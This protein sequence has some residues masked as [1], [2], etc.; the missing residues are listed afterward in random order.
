MRIEKRKGRSIFEGLPIIL[1]LIP[2]MTY[3]TGKFVMQM[4][5][6]NLEFIWWILIPLLWVGF[7]FFQFK[8]TKRTNFGG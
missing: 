4:T 7:F 2:T 1:I 5:Y 3:L 6:N 8:I